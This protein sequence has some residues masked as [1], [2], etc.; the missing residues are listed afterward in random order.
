MPG[1]HLRWRKCPLPVTLS[2]WPWEA[3]DPILAG[4]LCSLLG[5]EGC[6]ID[7]TICGSGSK[8]LNLPKEETQGCLMLL[9][10]SLALV[11]I[12]MLNCDTPNVGQRY[13]FSSSETADSV[14]IR[15]L[16]FFRNFQK[17]L[18][19]NFTIVQLENPWCRIFSTSQHFQNLTSLGVGWRLWGQ[20]PG[21]HHSTPE[22]PNRPRSF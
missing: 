11:F 15:I 12:F 7:I 1:G 4:A 18:K 20:W 5:S 14:H 9:P 3:L 13:F 16:L 21:S 10:H 2:P 8:V 17:H 6:G 19:F 22:L